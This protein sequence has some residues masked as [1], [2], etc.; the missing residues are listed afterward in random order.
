MAFMNVD[1]APA[2]PPQ[3]WFQ[4]QNE[5]WSDVLDDFNIEMKCIVDVLVGFDIETK[6]IYEDVLS[7]DIEKKF[8]VHLT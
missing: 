4:Y 1:A 6:Y 2:Q 8:R 3:H 7:F 5:I